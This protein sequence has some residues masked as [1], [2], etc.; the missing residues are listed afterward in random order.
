MKTTL[1][2]LLFPVVL[3]AQPK[4][5]ADDLYE[6]YEPKPYIGG[7]SFGGSLL[8]ALPLDIDF[9]NGDLQRTLNGEIK[10]VQWLRV[11][12]ERLSLIHI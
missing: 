11:S 2:L 9:A 3:I 12:D 6:E 10:R 7:F 8:S 5:S 4:G 1:F